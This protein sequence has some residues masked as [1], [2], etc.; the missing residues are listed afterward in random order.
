M[1]RKTMEMLKNNGRLPDDTPYGWKSFDK[2]G[3]G[4]RKTKLLLVY[5][6]T[7][8]QFLLNSYPIGSSQSQVF[9]LWGTLEVFSWL[10][11]VTHSRCSCRQF[12]LREVGKEFNRFVH[13]RYW[14]CRHPIFRLISLLAMYLDSKEE[15]NLKWIELE[16]F[17]YIRMSLIC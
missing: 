17:H 3:M 4:Y 15:N 7:V 1:F 16:R 14:T 12:A 13:R 9:H 6:L 8:P 5:F 2:L 10:Q 11:Y